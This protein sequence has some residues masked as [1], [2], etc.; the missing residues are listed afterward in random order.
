LGANESAAAT[1]V[2]EI[3]ASAEEKPALS[4]EQIA[5]INMRRDACMSHASQRIGEFVW[6]SRNG[7]NTNYSLMVEDTEHPE[8]NVCFAKVSVENRDERVDTDTIPARYFPLGQNVV[9]ADWVPVEDLQARI[10]EAGKSRRVLG[11]V[12][13]SLAGAGI[14]VG[15]SE[16]AM[17]IAA[18]QGSKSSLMGQHALEG[19]ELLISEIKKIKQEDARKYTEIIT[20]LQALDTACDAIKEAKCLP[21]ECKESLNLYRNLHKKL[22]SDS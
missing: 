2:E 3:N 15:I 11:A 9:C 21:D 18:K 6:A 17:A 19:Q 1:I 4:E 5:E 12:S 22:S 14:G 7:N 10:T 8:N 16:G 20:K 13:T